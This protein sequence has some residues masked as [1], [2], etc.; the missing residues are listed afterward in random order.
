MSKFY[1]ETHGLEANKM[2]NF[3]TFVESTKNRIVGDKMWFSS[4]GSLIPKLYG[5]TR[6]R[7]ENV[8]LKLFMLK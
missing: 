7:N 2:D 6:N 8:S 5:N 3:L 4:I 1:E